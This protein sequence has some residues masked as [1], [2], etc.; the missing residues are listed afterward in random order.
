M[1]N[2]LIVALVLIGQPG[3][4]SGRAE[5]VSGDTVSIDGVAYR[6]WGVQTPEPGAVCADDGVDP[7]DCDQGARD[8][9]SA[10]FAEAE[11]MTELL[12]HQ[13]HPRYADADLVRCDTQV[14]AGQTPAAARCEIL[15][16]ACMWTECEDRWSDLA[17][18]LV[19]AG[20]G[21]Q[22]RDETEGG[23]DE[24]EVVACYGGIGVWGVPD[25]A[26]VARAEPHLEGCDAPAMAAAAIGS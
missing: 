20:L 8:Y 16:V 23:F 5:V 12:T 13:G 2:A 19:E 4:V 21:V 3:M 25:G 6:L 24:A 26:G 1:L 22:R 14:A 7:F 10:R 9:L 15:G 17:G 18:E 11:E